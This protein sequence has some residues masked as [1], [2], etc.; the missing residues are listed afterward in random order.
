MNADQI[1]RLIAELHT[2]SKLLA[3]NVLA[4]KSQTDRVSVLMDFGFDNKEIADLLAMKSNVVS[5]FKS[6]IESRKTEKDTKEKAIKP[7]NAKD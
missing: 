4:E 2:I 3:L 1:D 5:A 7:E 6:R